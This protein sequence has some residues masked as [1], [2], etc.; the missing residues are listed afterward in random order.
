VVAYGYDK[1]SIA[2]DE[3]ESDKKQS[4]SQA[5]LLVAARGF[6]LSSTFVRAEPARECEVEGT[7]L[8]ECHGRSIRG[9]PNVT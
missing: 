8:H 2:E 7:S 4:Q 1:Q 9:R 6:H 5:G 3:G